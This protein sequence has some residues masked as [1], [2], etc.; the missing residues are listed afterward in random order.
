MQYPV[1]KRRL[2]HVRDLLGRVVLAHRRLPRL[3]PSFSPSKSR[4]PRIRLLIQVAILPTFSGPIQRSA[5][6]PPS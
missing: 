5:Q 3:P 2:I 1:G 6:H 4:L